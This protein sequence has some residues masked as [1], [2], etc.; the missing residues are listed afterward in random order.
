MNPQEHLNFLKRETS[1]KTFIPESCVVVSSIYTLD[2]GFESMVFPAKENGEILDYL[3]YE[4][5]RYDSFKEMQKGHKQLCKKWRK[6][7]GK[8]FCKD[9]D[10]VY[11]KHMKYKLTN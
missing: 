1:I 10:E 5:K 2:A 6:R 9:L 7:L 3:D 4:C 8:K 11:A